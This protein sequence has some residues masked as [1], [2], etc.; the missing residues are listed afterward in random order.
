MSATLLSRRFT[1]RPALFQRAF[2]ASRASFLSVGDAVPSVPVQ[3]GSPGNV[4]SLADETK[5]GKYVIV[6]VPGAFS[7]ACSASHAP[8]YISHTGELA[9][10]GVDGVFIVAVNDAFVTKAW[11]D[12]L[13]TNDKVRFIADSH[14]EFS[15]EFG[16][17]FDASKFFG[18]ERTK[19]YA[20]V[21]ENGKVTEA[22]I[23]PDSTGLSVSVAE[24]VLKNL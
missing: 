24:N 11:A 21:V 20:A 5:K 10:K 7:P 18:N 3:E 2:H 4:V 1:A 17:L 16:T 15:K 12:S 22:F 14:G 13:K 8:G 19:R 23:E 9:K 6:G